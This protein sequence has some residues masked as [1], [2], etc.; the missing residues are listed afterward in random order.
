MTL[1]SMA[2]KINV[3]RKD[4][5]AL[6][7]LLAKIGYGYQRRKFHCTVGFIEKAIP[8]E[9]SAS[10]GQ[11]IAQALQEFLEN[12]PCFYEVDQAAHL[13]GRVITFLPTT[14]SQENLKKINTWVSDKVQEISKGRWRLNKES[15]PESY[16]PHFT[17]WHTRRPDRRFKKL[18]EFAETHPTYHLSQ[19]AYVIFN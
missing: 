10:F 5:E 11:N 12:E 6:S 13:F 1:V 14:T 4:Q 8:S 18:K 7:H 9:E 19:A 17:L 3:N 16:I 15:L 2:I